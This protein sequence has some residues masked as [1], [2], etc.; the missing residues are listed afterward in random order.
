MQISKI[1]RNRSIVQQ[2]A[3]DGNGLH[4]PRQQLA[5]VLQRGAN[6]VFQSA[7]ARHL[8]ADNGYAFDV[9]LTEDFGQLLAV[10]HI[11]QLGTADER[12]LPPDKILME[13]CVRVSGA[14]CRDEQA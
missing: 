9:V 6:G 7:A 13:V 4:L 3:L 10:I 12:Y 8:H 5:A 11:I 2:V 14:V 1:D